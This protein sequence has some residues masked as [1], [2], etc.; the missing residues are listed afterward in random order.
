MTIIF[1]LIISVVSVSVYFGVMLPKKKAYEAAQKKIDG[2]LLPTPKEI[3]DF[4][5]TNSEGKSFTK[6]NL[7]DKW[8]MMFFGFTNC[9]L[10]CP[11][12]LA[13]LN[14]MYKILQVEL[15]ANE[16]PQVMFVSVDPERDTVKRLKDYVKAFNPH[17]LGARGSEAETV[18][19][20][21]QLHIAAA[22]MQV[23]GGKKDNYFINH[24]AE[25]LIFNPKGQLVAYLTYPHKP[26]S[27]VKDYKILLNTGDKNARH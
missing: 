1:I 9:G 6:K 3:Q 18:A 14:E 5:F 26:E 24:S 8:T 2:I 15:P 7:N 12:S 16:M 19:L 23:K 22:K 27:L 13:A 21:Q 25:I 20:T 10:V 4:K 17:F 11:T